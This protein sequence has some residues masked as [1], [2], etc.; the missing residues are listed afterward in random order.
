MRSIDSLFPETEINIQVYLF[1]LLMVDTA[2]RF[3]VCAQV[4]YF[5][6]NVSQS[7]KFIN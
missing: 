3:L 7:A 2:H 1:A 5:G 6:M 4:C